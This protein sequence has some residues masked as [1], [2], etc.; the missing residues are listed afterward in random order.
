MFSGRK[1]PA[2]STLQ[3]MPTKWQ[4]YIGHFLPHFGPQS[5]S[6]GPPST[7]DDNKDF[8]PRWWFKLLL[9]KARP[10]LCK[11]PRSSLCLSSAGSQGFWK[12]NQPT[13]LPTHTFPMGCYVVHSQV[14]LWSPACTSARSTRPGYRSDP[15]GPCPFRIGSSDFTKTSLTCLRRNAIANWRAESWKFLRAIANW[16][17]HAA[18]QWKLVSRRLCWNSSCGPAA[19]LNGIHLQSIA[20]STTEPVS[21]WGN[22]NPRSNEPTKSTEACPKGEH[23]Q[24]AFCDARKLRF[25]HPQSSR[26]THIF[27]TISFWTRRRMARER[28][29]ACYS[30]SVM[31]ERM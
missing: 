20:L 25:V 10:H 13:G 26:S 30:W 5:E 11:T 1:A 15:A 7:N 21:V 4:V 3:E 24:N 31:I 19:A 2:N 28:R 9:G 22:R 16:K 17:M 27:C 29:R 23:E 18:L 12:P 8:W 14:T 6:K